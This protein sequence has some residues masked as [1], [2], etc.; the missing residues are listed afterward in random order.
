[1]RLLDAVRQTYSDFFTDSYVSA[2][3]LH[4]LQACCCLHQRTRNVCS[5]WLCRRETDH[6]CSCTAL[7]EA[8]LLPLGPCA[9]LKC[10]PLA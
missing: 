6:Q 2:H 4:T 1:M 3:Q 7:F 9:T 8:M 5:S 10:W